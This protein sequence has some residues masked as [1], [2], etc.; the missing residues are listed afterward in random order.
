MAYCG[1]ALFFALSRFL[2]TVMPKRKILY[3]IIGIM[4]T[5]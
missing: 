5:V 2:R 1:K 3:V 4:N